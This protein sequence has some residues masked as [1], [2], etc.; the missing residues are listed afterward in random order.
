MVEN[1]SAT[2]AVGVGGDCCWVRGSGVGGVVGEWLVEKG[3]VTL[4]N[5]PM[6]Q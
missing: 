1:I 4:A 3:G 6:T 2:F 5:L